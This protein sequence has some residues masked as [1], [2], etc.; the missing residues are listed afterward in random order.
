VWVN[1]D[2]ILA[3]MGALVTILTA[4]VPLARFVRTAYEKRVGKDIAQQKP[5]KIT[6]DIDGTP[7]QIEVSDME[8]TEGI[9]RLAQRIQANNPV[10]ATK[11]KTQT[12]IKVKGSLPK[13]PTR[14]RR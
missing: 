2:V 4:A 3:D 12:K 1:K 10:V 5:I 9:L 13:S 8:S 7:I 14:K 6:F 11:V